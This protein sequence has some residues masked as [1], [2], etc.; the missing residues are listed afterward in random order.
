M[1]NRLAQTTHRGSRAEIKTLPQGKEEWT[2]Q[3]KWR[4]RIAIAVLSTGLLVSSTVWAGAITTL[5]VTIQQLG[6]SRFA[7]G[8]FV[9]ARYS[10][11]TKQFIGCTMNAG[12]GQQPITCSARDKNGNTVTCTAVPGD[13]GFNGIKET[14]QSITDV[15]TILFEEFRGGCATLQ[16]LNS[17]RNLS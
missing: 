3:T 11:D 10:S 9:D 14:M 16:I 17:S 5:P 1:K 8:N 2:M 4:T 7:S 12:F 13:V 6:S 15:S